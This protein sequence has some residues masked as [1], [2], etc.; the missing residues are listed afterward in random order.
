MD[1][2]KE[3][4]KMVVALGNS[5]KEHI[6]FMSVVCF[7]KSKHSNEEIYFNVSKLE[8]ALFRKLEASFLYFDRDENNERIY[9][10]DKKRYVV[11]PMALIFNE[12]NYY[13][14]CF[15]ATYDGVT[16]YRVDCMMKCRS[17]RSLY[18][19]VRSYRR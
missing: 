12:D 16:H 3:L 1:K 15:S 4:V 11:E 2:T 7:N 5:R 19:R 14:I 9:R 6:L 13:L 18:L 8:E 10:K 17:R